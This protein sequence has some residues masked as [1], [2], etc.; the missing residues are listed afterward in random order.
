M[1]TNGPGVYGFVGAAQTTRVL[2]IALAF[3][4]VIVCFAGWT[5]LMIR[6][7]RREQWTSRPLTRRGSN[8]VAVKHAARSAA[9]CV[10]RARPVLLGSGDGRVPQRYLLPM[11]YAVAGQGRTVNVRG[12][13]DR[14]HAMP[15]L[16][17]RRTA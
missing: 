7:Q 14:A 2:P 1:A 9:P 10:A 17:L 5:V 8:A 16:P 15:P 11:P 12:E 6:S 13:P 3:F 4:G